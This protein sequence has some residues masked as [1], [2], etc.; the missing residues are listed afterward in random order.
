MKII[1]DAGKGKLTFKIN[2][3]HENIVLWLFHFYIL[4]LFQRIENVLSE[5]CQDGS[6]IYRKK[7]LGTYKS[8]FVLKHGR[9]SIMRKYGGLDQR[10]GQ[11]THNVDVK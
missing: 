2:E 9:Q 4:K 8:R 1:A 5:N 6:E 10:K 7:Y 3:D 11:P